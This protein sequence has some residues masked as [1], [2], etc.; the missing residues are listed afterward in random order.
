MDSRKTPWTPNGLRVDSARTPGEIVG[1]CKVLDDLDKDE[2]D[3]IVS[4][5]NVL[6]S[7]DLTKTVSGL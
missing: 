5:P 1:Q 6:A 7:V 4:E 2:D 3:G